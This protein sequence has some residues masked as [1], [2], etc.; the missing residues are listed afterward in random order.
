MENNVDTPNIAIGYVANLFSRMMVFKKTGDI[1]Y[2]HTHQFHHLT[3]LAKGTLKVTVDGTPTVFKAPYM[4]YIDKDKNHELVA[5]EDETIAFC[6]HAVRT[7]DQTEII[8]PDMIPVREEDIGNI[9]S[10]MPN[11]RL[12]DFDRIPSKRL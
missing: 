2:G 6:I 1:E 9:C 11:P 4:I 12:M 3:L 5:M 8:D 10:D 7:K